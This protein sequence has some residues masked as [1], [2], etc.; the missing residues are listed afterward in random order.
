TPGAKE[1][2]METNSLSK[3]FSLAG[4][5][6][7][8]IVGNADAIKILQELKTNLD[9]GTFKPIQEAAITALDHAEEITAPL[10]EEFTK[11][12]QILMAG[13]N[14]LGWEATPSAGGM[15]V[16]AKYP[17]KLDDISFVLKAIEET[18]VVMVPGSV[19]GSEGAGYVRIALVQSQENL[20][21]AI[22]QLKELQ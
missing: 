9:Y 12:H 3:S 8:Y 20:R 22:E 18:G 16:W 15:F 21:Q 13:M 1:V 5:R 10:R 14:V 19:F 2:G 17:G 11:R 4:A 6:I 7:A